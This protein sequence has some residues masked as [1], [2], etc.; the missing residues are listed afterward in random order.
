MKTVL[1]FFLG[2]A[3]AAN[4]ATVTINPVAD[5]SLFENNPDNNLGGIGFF[6]VGFTVITQGKQA[7]GL[8]KFDVS[9]IPPGS[10]IT[11]AQLALHSA[12]SGPRPGNLTVG[13]HRALVS[14]TEGDNEGQGSGELGSFADEGESSW[15]RRF[16]PST[17][18]GAPGGQAGADYVSA[19]STT[20]SLP[21]VGAATASGAQLAADIQTWVNNS[22]TNFGWFL[23]PQ[24]DVPNRQVV[25]SEGGANQPRLTIT[26]DEP[27][28]EPTEPTISNPTIEGTNFRF[29]FSA[30]A[31]FRY[32][33][34]ARNSLS[35]GT[36]EPMTNFIAQ[37]TTAAVITDPV[38]FATNKFYR[39]LVTAPQ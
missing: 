27:V 28:L 31:P 21:Q 10:T 13:I 25:S 15:N 17:T 30:E 14:W 1:G 16:A 5:T 34:E 26:Y 20:F 32:T 6:P 19:A 37:A 29:T 8:V 4:A 3:V 39:V 2:A 36:W 22:Q 7:R 24:N 23:I 33:V 38:N 35:T 9:S 11:S 12:N 18:W